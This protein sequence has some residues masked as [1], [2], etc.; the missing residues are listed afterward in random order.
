MTKPPF[1]MYVRSAAAWVSV[2]VHQL[3]SMMYATGYL[4]SAGSSSA[5]VLISSSLAPR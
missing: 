3:T 1:C 5:S 4:N 2:S